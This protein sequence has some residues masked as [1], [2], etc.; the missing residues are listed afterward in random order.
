G[1]E[2]RLDYPAHVPSLF[3]RRTQTATETSEP[4]SA[5][6][7]AAAGADPVPDD[8]GSAVPDTGPVA[9]RAGVKPK[10]YTPGKGRAT[11]KRRDA[12]RRNA[13]PPPKDR[14]EAARRMRE[15]QRTERAEAREAMMRGDERYLQPR[16]QGPERALT[17]NIVDA[18]RNVGTWF[19]AGAVVI[20][21]GTWPGAFPPQVRFV[22]DLFWVVLLV[23]VIVDSFVLCRLVRRLVRDRYPDTTQRFGGLYFYAVMRALTLRRMRIPKPQVKPGDAI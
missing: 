2:T 6:P 15:R 19:F 7:D 8:T 20:L 1:R 17:R 23:A 22:F 13:E 3:R 10:A 18:R 21:I 12:R 9:P 14:K 5:E 11:P 16:D 4:A